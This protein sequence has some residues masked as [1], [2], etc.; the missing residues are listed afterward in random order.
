[1][2]E[3]SEKTDNTKR[4]DKRGILRLDINKPRNSS[5][6]VEFRCQPE[7]ISEVTKKINKHL[8]RSF[9]Y[10]KVEMHCAN[11]ARKNITAKYTNHKPT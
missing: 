11:E 3:S 8:F 6:S 2:S 5:G 1:M 7:L 4:G 10:K 9:E